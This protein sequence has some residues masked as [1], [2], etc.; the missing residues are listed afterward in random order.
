MD[1]LASKLCWLNLLS[2]LSWRGL[3]LRYEKSTLVG[4]ASLRGV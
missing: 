3:W 1:E 2:T 4:R